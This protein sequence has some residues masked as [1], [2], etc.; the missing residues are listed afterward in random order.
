VLAG[1]LGVYAAAWWATNALG[2]NGYGGLLALPQQIGVLRAVP[3]FILAV[4][5][6]PV[7]RNV[8]WVPQ[9][10]VLDALG[11]TTFCL[12]VIHWPVLKMMENHGFQGWGYC[13]LSVVIIIIA[14]QLMHRYVDQPIQQILR[15]FG[16]RI[17]W[18][19]LV[20]GTLTGAGRKRASR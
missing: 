20:P 7:V 3:L 18:D 8:P 15:S 6:V 4:L 16:N 14:A 11:D 13:V 10:R 1:A 12:Y 9:S 2:Y 19:S 17:R 5:A